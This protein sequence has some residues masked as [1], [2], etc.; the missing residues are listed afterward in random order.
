[1]EQKY[2]LS[3]MMKELPIY[4]ISIDL[5]E[6]ETSVEFNSLVRDPA[7]EISFQTFSQAKKYQ[8]NDEE[9]VITGVAISADTPIYR[10]DQDSNEEYY[11]VFTKAAIKDIIHDYARRGNFNNVNIEHNSSNVVDGIYMIHSYQIDNDKGFTAPERF[12]DANDGSW[13]VSY[14]V[15]DKDVWEKAKEGKFTGFSV[16]GYFQITA[17][18]RTI[19]SEMMAQIFKAL[20]DLSGTIKHSIIK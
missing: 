4:E 3:N 6:A 8:F 7:H 14:K 19:E 1:M 16:E 2:I 11:V 17:T 13:I 18:D 20:N 15:T 12:H 10:F 9:Q 5:N